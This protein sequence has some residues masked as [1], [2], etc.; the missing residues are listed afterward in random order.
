MYV[1]I[2]IH[3]YI[4][5]VR[6]KDRKGRTYWATR[7][8][9]GAAPCVTLNF[10]WRL[11]PQ[12]KRLIHEVSSSAYLFFCP[13]THLGIYFGAPIRAMHQQGAMSHGQRCNKQPRPLILYMYV[14]MY[15]RYNIV[16]WAHLF[17]THRKKFCFSSKVLINI[18]VFACN[19]A[20]TQHSTE[21]PA[22]RARSQRD[23]EQGGGGK[24]GAPE[25][26]AGSWERSCVPRS[27]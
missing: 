10:H 20:C 2:Y 27:P 26:G 23:E 24:E 7:G 22:N 15:I 3:V 1:G 21:S 6:K 11:L 12:T 9:P 13:R 4:C 14:C 5:R 16:L 17:S 18:S 8:P 19:M 25:G